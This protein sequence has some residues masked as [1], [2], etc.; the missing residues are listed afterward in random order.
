MT[1]L[2]VCPEANHDYLNVAAALIRCL[3]QVLRV[4]VDFGA[5]QLE[6]LSRQRCPGLLAE[7]HRALMLAGRELVAL[8]AD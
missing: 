3:P 5:R 1:T 6:I 8:R 2:T 7:M 4:R